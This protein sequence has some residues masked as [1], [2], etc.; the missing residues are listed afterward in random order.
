MCIRDSVIEVSVR[1]DHILDVR[2]IEPELLQSLDDFVFDRVV[3]DRVE[4]DDA[5]RGRDCPRRVLRHADVVHVVEHFHRLGVPRL[6]CGGRRWSALASLSTARSTTTWR[7]GCLLYT[8][9]S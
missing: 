9:P 4:D 7:R 1:D 5:L 6:A 8:S 3:V 2:R